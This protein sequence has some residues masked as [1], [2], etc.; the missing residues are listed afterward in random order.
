MLRILD[1][2]DENANMPDD[3]IEPVSALNFLDSN[4]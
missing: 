3:I 1:W 2:K 4:F